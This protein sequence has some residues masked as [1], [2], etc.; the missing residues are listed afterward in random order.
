MAK[1]LFEGIAAA[2]GSV[3]N[4]MTWYEG[5]DGKEKKTYTWIFGKQCEGRIRK[6]IP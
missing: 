2:H 1:G 5:V 6:K 3:G 4:L